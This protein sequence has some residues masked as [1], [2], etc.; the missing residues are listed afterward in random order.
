MCYDVLLLTLKEVH[1]LFYIL[2]ACEVLDGI[3]GNVKSLE[4]T[5]IKYI[6]RT[7]KHWSLLYARVSFIVALRIHAVMPNAVYS[8]QSRNHLYLY[9]V[10]I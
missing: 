1:F 8:V 6:H 4:F 2:S 3:Q 9:S 7:S 10:Y 5:P